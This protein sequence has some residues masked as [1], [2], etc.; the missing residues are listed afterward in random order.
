MRKYSFIILLSAFFISSLSYSQTNPVIEY[1]LSMSEPQSHY[2]EVEM[3]VSG[4]DKDTIEFVMPVWA[5]G[6]Y[7]IR[8]FAKN[9]SFFRAIDGDNNSLL[10][11]KTNK[12]TWKV[13]LTKSKSVTI[14][15]KVYAFEM[16]VRTSFI[17]VS[18]GYLNGT[19]V[20]MYVKDLKNKPSTLKI[21]PY[22]DW[23]KVNTGLKQLKDKK[24]EYYS[25]NY[26][27]LADSP[28]EIGNQNVYK[29]TAAG[30][31]H[32]LVMY[33]EGNYN[34]DSLKIQMAQ[35]VETATKVI[36][37]NP[38]KEYT[39][40]VHN[41]GN[42]GGGLEHL[43][44]TTLQFRRWNYDTK[45]RSISFLGLVAH[46][47]FHLWNVKRIRPIQLGPFDYQ[48]ENY[49]K[50]LW[51]MEGV[52]TYYGS[53]ILLR[54][55]FY[56][57]DKYLSRVARSISSLENQPGNIVQSAA[58]SSYDTWIK[59]YRSNENS[60]NTEIS[61]YGKGSVLGMLLDLEIINNTNGEKSYDD[62]L[63]L[64]YNKFYKKLKRG[65]T[66]K[67]MKKAVEEIAGENLDDFFANY[68]NGTKEINYNKY[69]GYAGLKLIDI[70]ENSNSK[71]LG[72]SM[73]T[74]NGKLIIRRVTN[75]T[76]AYEAGLNVNDEIIAVNNYRID[77]KLL[78][79]FVNENPAGTKLDFLLSRDGKLI[80]L[81]V[82]LRNNPVKKFVIEQ[83]EYQTEKQALVYKKWLRL[84]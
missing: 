2:F 76:P 75:G 58:M 24:W 83:T 17:D 25:P 57:P 60:Y 13:F 69:L 38:N 4:Y 39:F 70:N 79:K 61:Y 62:V 7:L 30:V 44:S 18:H 15:Y 74:Q 11:E 63:R 81:K 5:P 12:Y 67:E 33:G 55:G 6:S 68:V 54:A 31:A 78:D 49:T 26:D 71:Y 3:K 52:T 29:F 40:I 84:K 1:T 22:K 32:N 9:V 35:I 19:S 66:E 42:R 36:G 16:S 27:I 21:I 56:T 23:K 46:E 51:E 72:V 28:I 37:E 20:F 34:I 80:N 47:Y 73:R 10:F 77:N 8:E 82:K 65:F 41:L 43:N 14:S 50:L 45:N 53:Q 59:F 64:L 48:N